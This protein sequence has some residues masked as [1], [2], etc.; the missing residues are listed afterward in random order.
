MIDAIRK[1]FLYKPQLV[2]S[3][4]NMSEDEGIQIEKQKR[5]NSI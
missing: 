3:T 4:G 1:S 5:E 2:P